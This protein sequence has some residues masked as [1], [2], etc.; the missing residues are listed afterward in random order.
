[1]ALSINS[2]TQYVSDRMF[3]IW[4]TF[5]L[6]S[7]YQ[8]GKGI[9]CIKYPNWVVEQLGLALKDVNSHDTVQYGVR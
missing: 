1:M 9:S 3:K 6:K 7:S 2:L 5:T 4:E 8:T